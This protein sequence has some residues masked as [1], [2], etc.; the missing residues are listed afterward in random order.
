MSSDGA[1]VRVIPPFLYLGSVLLGV[2]LHGI[3]EL[4]FAAGSGLR[5]ALG[6]L[7]I[8]AG[9]ALIASAFSIF[10]RMGQDPDPRAPT[11]EL[12][13]AG[14]YRFT[15][16]PMYLGLSLIQLGIGV[17]LGNAWILIL[18]VPT[19][20]TVTHGVIQREEEYLERKFGNDYESFKASVRR[21][22]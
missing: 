8:C 18:L 21:W 3:W 2:L 17:A 5:I 22:L 13:R 19:L 4:G 10:K 15:R 20:I 14:P 11:P 9:A 16:N 12:S 7:A 1:D 6:A